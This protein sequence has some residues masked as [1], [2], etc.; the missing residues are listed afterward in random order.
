MIIY[1]AQ[2]NKLTEQKPRMRA[3]LRRGS[4]KNN[5]GGNTMHERQQ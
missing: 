4:D 2:N 5:T 1:K 3:E